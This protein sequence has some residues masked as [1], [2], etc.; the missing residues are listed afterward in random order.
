VISRLAAELHVA[1]LL[2]MLAG[3]EGAILRL[4]NHTDGDRERVIQRLRVVQEKIAAVLR[5][6]EGTG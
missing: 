3:V 5:R 1:R 6:L 4:E 2:R